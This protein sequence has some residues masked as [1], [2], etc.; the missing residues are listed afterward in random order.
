MATNSIVIADMPIFGIGP[1][2][3]Q[4]PLCFADT[5]RTSA[6]NKEPDALLA[7]VDA[8]AVDWLAGACACA[9]TK[10]QRRPV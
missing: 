5:L 8:F 9:N 10:S 4:H 1:C 3:H 7:G 6:L 2:F